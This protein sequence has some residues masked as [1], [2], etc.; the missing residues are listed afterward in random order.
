[1]TLLFQPLSYGFEA[2]LTNEFHTLNGTCSQLVPMGE[3]YENVS[4]ANQVCTA[5][6]SLP[7]Q[8]NVD[9]NRF[10]ELSYSY[11]YSHLWRNFGIVVA[12]TGAFLLSLMIL[13]EFNTRSATET[14]MTL[15]KRGAA[16]IQPVE[17]NDEEKGPG[18]PL[19]TSKERDQEEES[20][21]MTPQMSDIFSWQNI[22]YTV[23]LGKGETRQLLDD[24]S[25][26]V[27]PG[28]LT[29]LM[30]VYKSILSH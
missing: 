7:G 24:I 23:P 5:V 28:K 30:Y 8:A 18:Q 22:R 21:E 1:M 2:I 29:A 27:V 12:Y 17:A 19:T 14:A 6:G 4:L 11:S 25:G 3:G 15:Y 16:K 13:T 9:G 26:Y 10:M 20:L